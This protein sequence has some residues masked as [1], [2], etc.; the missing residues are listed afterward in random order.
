LISVPLQFN[1]DA[2]QN[3]L[4]IRGDR[5]EESKMSYDLSIVPTWDGTVK[6]YAYEADAL[7]PTTEKWINNNR[8]RWAFVLKR[9][10]FLSYRNVTVPASGNYYLRLTAIHDKPG[11][12]LIEVLVDG[13]PAGIL[14]FNKADDTWGSEGFPLKLDEGKHEVTLQFISNNIGSG[15]A[16]Q[17]VDAVIEHFELTD[18]SIAEGEAPDERLE[19]GGRLQGA[20]IVLKDAFLKASRQGGLPMG[21]GLEPPEKAFEYAADEIINGEP[22]IIFSVQP[23]S[24]GLTL[25]SPPV[26]LKPGM[27]LYV[28]G[29]IKVKK[30][31]NHS[32]NMQIAYISAD[33]KMIGAQWVNVEGITKTTDWVRF[34]YFKPTVKNARWAIITYVVYP[35]SS[36]PGD[37]VAE[38]LFSNFHFE[39]Y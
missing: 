13:K 25:M 17:D 7:H 28:S 36:K 6:F 35:N 31:E 15:S 32:A 12:V 5:G 30:L 14:P 23:L 33:K 8:G 4:E 29:K 19:I 10:A 39:S 11:P 16:D 26:E 24:G 3:L 22:A 1:A 2:G 38:V 9:N 27:F 34:C 18:Y 37:S 21:W 20:P